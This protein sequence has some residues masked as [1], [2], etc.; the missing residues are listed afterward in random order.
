MVRKTISM[1]DEM[2]RW[3]KSRIKSG[4]FNN[5]SEYFRDLVRGDKEKEMA[6]QQLTTLLQAAEKSG[7]S[8]KSVTDIWEV[9]EK[10]S[11]DG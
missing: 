8:Q 11:S 5:D 6:K 10:N 3:V 1:P 2:E 4:Q 7:V 9:A